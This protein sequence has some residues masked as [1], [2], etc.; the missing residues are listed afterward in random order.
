VLHGQ[1]S[2]VRQQLDERQ[3]QKVRAVL[4]AKQGA[5][6][7][8]SDDR[9]FIEAVLWWLRTG[10]PWRDLPTE[11]GSWKTVFNRF[12]RWAQ[13]LPLDKELYKAR[14]A[15]ECTFNLLKQS[16]R[17]ATRYEKTLRNYTAVTAIGCALLWLRI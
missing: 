6:R 16:R 10:V 14:S 12:D 1:A 9:N 11:F 7:P 2:M 5:G 8:G 17:F 13:K 4:R 3:W 15:I